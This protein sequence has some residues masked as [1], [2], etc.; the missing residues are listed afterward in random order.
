MAGRSWH[1]ATQRMIAIVRLQHHWQPQW[2]NHGHRGGLSME[3]PA[4]ELKDRSSEYLRWTQS[5]EKIAISW[6]GPPVEW[7]PPPRLTARSIEKD[8]LA[9][10]Q[11]LPSIKVGNGQKVSGLDN[12]VS[13]PKVRLST[14]CS[15]CTANDHIPRY[16]RLP[17]TLSRRDCLTLCGDYHQC[18]A[19]SPHAP[20]PALRG[21]PSLQ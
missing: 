16:L 12:L 3:A 21:A 19:R 14:S 18:G 10:I 20:S 4:R 8:T 1:S 11:M 15:G 17:E 9:R 6:R 2:Q 5:G 7:L 13:V